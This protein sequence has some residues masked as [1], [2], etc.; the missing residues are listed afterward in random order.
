MD[1]LLFLEFLE[2]N[3][4]KDRCIKTRCNPYDEYDYDDDYFKIRFRLSKCTVN[5]LLEQV[6]VRT[7]PL[8][9]S[10]SYYCSKQNN[11]INI[12]LQTINPSVFQ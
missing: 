10:Y 8:T 9:P 5:K 3:D 4:K 1:S 2:Q 6:G 7:L 12:G 11:T